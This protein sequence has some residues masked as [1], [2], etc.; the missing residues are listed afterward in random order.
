MRRK[1]GYIFKMLNVEGA[2]CGVLARGGREVPSFGS[3]VTTAAQ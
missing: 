3:F 1:K 2:N